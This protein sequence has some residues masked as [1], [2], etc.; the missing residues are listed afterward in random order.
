MLGKAFFPS[1]TRRSQM[2]DP[3]SSL[4]VLEWMFCILDKFVFC[5]LL[6]LIEKACYLVGLHNYVA[7]KHTPFVISS[8]DS[9]SG[10]TLEVLCRPFFPGLAGISSLA[11]AVR[12]PF[13]SSP[14]CF[15][16]T[17]R[18]VDCGVT[19]TWEHTARPFH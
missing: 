7:S 9:H 6:G 12:F 4:L 14:C 5:S 17:A 2:V 11:R 15:D 19:N 1:S 8:T 16:T 10:L 3:L 13:F 18:R